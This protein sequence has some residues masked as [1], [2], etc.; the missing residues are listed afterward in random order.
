MTD[1]TKEPDREEPPSLPPSSSERL[2]RRN[3]GSAPPHSNPRQRNSL[4]H[5]GQRAQHKLSHF[6]E[7]VKTPL[8][9]APP[10][11]HTPNSRSLSPS[12]RHQSN[13]AIPS[14][15][16]S[17]STFVP[18]TS[19]SLPRSNPKPLFPP[20]HPERQRNRVEAASHHPDLNYSIATMKYATTNLGRSPL[21]AEGRDRRSQPREGDPDVVIIDN[22]PEG[23]AASAGTPQQF[24]SLSKPSSGESFDDRLLGLVNGCAKISSASE[25]GEK[26]AAGGGAG[27]EP[28]NGQTE[29][30]CVND[31]ITPSSSPTEDM[32]PIQRVYHEKQVQEGGGAMR[33]HPPRKYSLVGGRTYK[34]QSSTTSKYFHPSREGGVSVCPT[35]SSRSSFPEYFEDDST[36][37]LFK[38]PTTASALHSLKRCAKS[39][40]QSSQRP[41]VP[42]GYV[43]TAPSS[44]DMEMGEDG[45]TR[46]RPLH[47]V[48]HIQISRSGGGS[49]STDCHNQSLTCQS[50]VSGQAQASVTGLDPSVQSP[51]KRQ[52]HQNPFRK[53]STGAVTT[54][55]PV[56]VSPGESSEDEGESN[57]T[58][59]SFDF[60]WRS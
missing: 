60:M 10:T 8:L 46:H 20:K 53:D 15:A 33:P 58:P 21:R 59:Q 9:A 38:S 17:Q 29:V 40:Q 18:S 52:G 54:E 22:P 34:P 27:P 13:R 42:R 50:G 14:V 12:Y 55:R 44:D 51:E 39:F 43:D 45:G 2:R 23:N 28:S 48:R 41:F 1:L 26:P 47:G 32:S 49:H 4:P 19:S 16:L 56:L 5:I 11:D 36:Q 37:D 3:T 24:I 31:H 57:H 6:V 35:L 7:S 30:V 25:R